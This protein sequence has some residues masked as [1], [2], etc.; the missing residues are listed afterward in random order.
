[1]QGS[2]SLGAVLCL[3]SSVDVTISA[4]RH[5]PVWDSRVEPAAGIG[6]YNS[7]LDSMLNTVNPI[8]RDTSTLPRGGW[9]VWQFVADNP[10][11]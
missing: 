3:S 1:M 4:A 7:S 6:T 8:M 11:Q 5:S 10:G 2:R 9:I